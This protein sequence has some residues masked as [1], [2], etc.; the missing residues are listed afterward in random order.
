MVK[1]TSVFPNEDKYRERRNLTIFILWYI[2][3]YKRLEFF[4][5]A[6]SKDVII[7]LCNKVYG[8]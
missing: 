1:G 8:G 6:Y 2:A 7:I 4:L 3:S 5:E